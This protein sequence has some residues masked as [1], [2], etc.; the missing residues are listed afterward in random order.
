MSSLADSK[1]QIAGIGH[2]YYAAPD[3]DDPDLYDYEFGDGTTLEKHGWT[4][5]GDTSSENLVEIESDGGEFTAKR[6]WDR[7]SARS[8]RAAVTHKLTINSVNLGRDTME[9]A[10]PGSTYDAAKDA[11]DLELSGSTE[12]A[13]LIVIVDGGEVSGFLYRRVTV[14][15]SLPTLSLEEFTEVKMSGNILSPNSGKKPVRVIPPRQVTGKGTAAPTVTGMSPKTGKAGAT[16]VITGT[17]FDGTRQV[18]FGEVN[19]LFQKNTATQITATVPGKA[20]GQ[21]DISVT[22]NMGTGKSTEKFTV[23]A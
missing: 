19:A 14:A 16:V 15:G 7:Q 8:S 2:V 10:F 9:S 13:F 22:N 11:W 6:T 23:Q 12:K 17:N 5:L 21:V 20:T 4:W 3:T 1:I 18:K